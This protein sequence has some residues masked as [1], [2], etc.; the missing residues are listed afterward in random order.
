MITNRKDTEVLKFFFEIIKSCVGI[1]QPKVFMSDMAS[2]LYNAW[3]IVMDKVNQHL[4][5]SW[6]VIKA[7]R[8]NLTKIKEPKD[9]DSIPDAKGDASV[10]NISKMS[11][12]D[13]RSDTFRKLTN[14]MR[15]LDQNKFIILLDDLKRDFQCDRDLK[16]FGD[17]FI[18]N[19]EPIIEQWAYCFRKNSTINTNMFVERMHKTLKYGFFQGKKMARLDKTIHCLLQFIESKVFDRLIVLHKGK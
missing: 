17:Y 2:E 12:K 1:V 7:W 9:D 13:K 16:A 19:Y 4:Y 6:H 14:A 11:N 3:S 8:D 10:K 5:C 18:K 15:E